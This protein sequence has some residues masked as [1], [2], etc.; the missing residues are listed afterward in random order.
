M[1]GMLGKFFIYGVLFIVFGLKIL[2]MGY[3]GEKWDKFDVYFKVVII[4]VIL[5]WRVI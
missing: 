4:L 1:S 2:K 3:S 5:N